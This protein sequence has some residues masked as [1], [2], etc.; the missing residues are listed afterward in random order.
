M[1][2][3]KT[4]KVKITRQCRIGG[5]PKNVLK[6]N[7][8]VALEWPMA[9]DLLAAGRAELVDGNA[10]TQT[11]GKGKAK[12]GGGG[13]SPKASNLPNPAETGGDQDNLGV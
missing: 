1:A 9:R 12:N 7:Q 3:Q 11:S 8:V 4:Y 2:K 10:S 6:V 5:G 13:P